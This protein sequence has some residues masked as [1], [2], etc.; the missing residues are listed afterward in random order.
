VE[1][2]RQKLP[3]RATRIKSFTAE[4]VSLISRM[5]I[6]KSKLTATRLLRCSLPSKLS[7]TETS[8][9][10]PRGLFNLLNEVNASLV[11]NLS[12]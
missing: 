7:L 11:A 10:E 6:T 4:T 12:T 3:T 9:E 1:H 2:Q 5:N 8:Q